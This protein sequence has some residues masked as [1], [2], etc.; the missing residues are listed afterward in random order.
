MK[1][2][3][4]IRYRDQLV[5]GNKKHQE[6][7]IDRL[8]LH[9]AFFF[10]KIRS[11]PRSFSRALGHLY[12]KPLHGDDYKSHHARLVGLMSLRTFNGNSMSSRFPVELTVGNT[13]T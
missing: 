4:I 1:F 11:L 9:M 2:I 6:I 3:V 10:H 13:P 5:P 7:K 12:L 8:W